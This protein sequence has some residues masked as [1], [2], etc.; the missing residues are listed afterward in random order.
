MDLREARAFAY[1]LTAR[2]MARAGLDNDPG[3]FLEA[4]L[5]RIDDKMVLMRILNVAAE[6]AADILFA[7]AVGFFDVFRRLLFT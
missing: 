5:A 1:A 6:V 4:N 7:D 2:A 3:G